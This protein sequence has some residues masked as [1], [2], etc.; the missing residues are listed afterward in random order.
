MDDDAPEAD[1]RLRRGSQTRRL[2]LARAVEVASVDGL[3]GLS[4]GQ[5]ATDLSI[6]KSGLFAHF[7]AKVQLQLDTIRAARRIYSDAVVAPAMQVPPG[8]A[9]VWALSDGWLDYSRRRVFPGGCFF[10][11][12]S[13][14]F[15]AR[16]GPVR[17]LLGS[18]SREWMALL[19]QTVEDARL[20]REVDLDEPAAQVA[21]EL[22]AFLDQANLGSLLGDE[23]TYERA[24]ASTR[25]TLERI[26]AP[27]VPLPWQG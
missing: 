16:P 14:E 22:Q 10:A 24:R 18:A 2:V 19:E 4:I 7:G 17:D 25:R 3:D 21:F 6:S 8:L 15:G 27:G 9:R 13:H 12:A 23:G 5:L 11:R 1:G 20:L 26:A